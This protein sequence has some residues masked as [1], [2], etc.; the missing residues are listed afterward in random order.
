MFCKNCGKK[1][2]QDAKFCNSCGT[3]VANSVSKEV[4]SDKSVGVKSK[5][6]KF[7]KTYAY[8][9]A[10][11]LVLLTIFFAFVG[12][13]EE[14]FFES[15]IGILILSAL[16]GILGTFMVKWCKKGFVYE[17]ASEDLNEAEMSRYKGL[18]G[19]LILVIIGLFATILWQA[20]GVYESITLFTDGI[21]EVLSNPAS[22]AYIP[23]YAGAL[24]FEFIAE[25][26]FLAF[27]VYLVFLFFKKSKKFPKYYV[28]FL[29]ASVV[30]VVLDYVVLSSLTIPSEM[31]QVVDEI[32]S[33]RGTEI[34]RTAIVAIIW[35]LYMTKSKRV[36]ATFV[37]D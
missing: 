3:A 6:F 20:Y 21:V 28:P 18:G 14:R 2:N 4:V 15:F 36:K 16:L 27:A 29:I 11:I 22:G 13:Y 31:R 35:G 9:T 32:L 12:S 34:A 26:L 5:E 7:G 37:E 23:G 17:N 24:K 30:Y 33:E 8:I 19:W 25:I 10:G 1:L